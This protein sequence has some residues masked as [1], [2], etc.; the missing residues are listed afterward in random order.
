[1]DDDSVLAFLLSEN[2]SP[3]N[4]GQKPLTDPTDLLQSYQ[5]AALATVSLVGR[6]I[7]PLIQRGAIEPW[8]VLFTLG[9]ATI[10]SET[11]GVSLVDVA[12]LK[13]LPSSSVLNAIPSSATRVV[14][15]EQVHRWSMKWTPL[16]LD[17]VS[18]I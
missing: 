12:L 14:V 3:R 17:V 4:G 8:T 2:Q 9:R 6:P 15:L 18:A 11:E 5:S 10:D 13:P 1:M 7:R 16:Y